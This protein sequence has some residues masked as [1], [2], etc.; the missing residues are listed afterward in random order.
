MTAV[1]DHLVSIVGVDDGH[2]TV[3]NAKV[4]T[5]KLANTKRS[6]GDASSVGDSGVEDFVVDGVME[7]KE[8]KTSK[9]TTEQKF[10]G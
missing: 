2:G 4:L 6:V 10:R 3:L 7:N 8:T 5:Q 9:D 1:Q